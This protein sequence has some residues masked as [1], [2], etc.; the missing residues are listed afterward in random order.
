MERSDAPAC[1]VEKQLGVWFVV[2]EIT[3]TS[4]AHLIGTRVGIAVARTIRRLPAS[5]REVVAMRGSTQEDNT[6][7][8][9]PARVKR[10][11]VYMCCAAQN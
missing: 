10:Q 4:N 3:Q 9:I 6:R 7:S 8:L 1:E 11:A 2:G 5:E